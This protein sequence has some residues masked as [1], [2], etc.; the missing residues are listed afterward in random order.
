M[1]SPD[2][3]ADL[4]TILDDPFA[5]PTDNMTDDG[6]VEDFYPQTF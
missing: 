2:V 3:M 6:I 5:D 1:T 4:S